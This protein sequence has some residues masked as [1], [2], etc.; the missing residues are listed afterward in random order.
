MGTLVLDSFFD[1]KA[2]IT[3]LIDAFYLHIVERYVTYNISKLV[4]VTLVNIMIKA[5][6][7]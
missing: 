1:L 2:P 5:N 3:S 6:S 7:V 4:Y